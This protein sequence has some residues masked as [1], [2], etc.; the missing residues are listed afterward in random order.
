MY[1]VIDEGL[2]YGL[3]T[4][5]LT[6]L[7]YTLGSDYE[8]FNGR[9]VRNGTGTLPPTLQFICFTLNRMTHR[10]ECVRLCFILSVFFARARMCA[11][12]PLCVWCRKIWTVLTS[13]RQLKQQGVSVHLSVCV[14]LSVRRCMRTTHA[15]LTDNIPWDHSENSRIPALLIYPTERAEQM[16]ILE[17]QDK[18][19]GFKRHLRFRHHD[20]LGLG[21]IP[22]PFR[23][24]IGIF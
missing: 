7:L 6:V 11:C 9:L 17:A 5:G 16:G 18:M 4:A 19:T 15:P 1:R 14:C 21:S 3:M 12:T 24:P 23:M 13:W 8:R 20:D 2:P 22:K 10:K